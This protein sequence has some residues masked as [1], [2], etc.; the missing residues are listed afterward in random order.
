MR[1]ARK[2]TSWV[3]CGCILLAMLPVVLLL[4]ASVA[5]DLEES[6]LGELSA[7]YESC[8]DP[9]AIAQVAGDPGGK[10]YG[11]YMFSSRAGVPKAFFEWCQASSNAYYRGIGNTL[12]EIYYYGTPGYGPLFDR[13][14]KSLAADNPVGFGRAQRDFVRSMYYDVYV[15]RIAQNVE[16]FDISNYS[17]ALRNV[18]WSRAIQHGVSGATNVFTRAMDTLGG[19]TNQPERELIDA[20]YAESGRLTVGDYP[21]MSGPTAR[22][23]GV[24]GMSMY[25]YTGCS[26]EIQLGVY[27]RLRINEPANAQAMLAEYGYGDAPVGEGS[28]I[29]CPSG[30]DNLAIGIGSSGLT[31]NTR[32]DGDDQQF[33]L[34][35]Y[36]SGYYTVTNAS[37]D[38][39]LTASASGVSLS[40][41]TAS[42]S[43]FWS[44]VPFNSGFLLKNRATDKC[45]SASSFSAGGQI[46]TSGENAQWQL[47]PGDANWSLDGAS[48]PSYASGL[49]VG[50]STFPFRGT[51]RS[52]YNITF[53]RAEVLNAS[54]A[55]C[56]YAEAA[57]D[58]PYYDLSQMD[59]AMTFGQLGAG[60]YTMRIT[61]TDSSDSHFELNE[62]FIVSDGNYMVTFD[63]AGG[64]C[65]VSARTFEAG[66]ILGE[67]P[68]PVWEGHVFVGWYDENGTLYT[69]ASTTPAHNLLLIARYAD[70]YTYTFYDYDGTTVLTSGSLLEGEVIP[71][72]ADPIR[73]SDDTNYYVFSGWEG[74]ESGMTM[75]TEDVSFTAQ[76]EA[77]PRLDITE[78]VPTGAFSLT[79]GYLRTIPVGTTAQEILNALEPHE[80]ITIRQGGET[81]TGKVGTGMTVD[82]IVDGNVIQSAV[83]VVTGDVNGDGDITLTDMVQIRSHLLGRSSLKDA[84]AEA[85]DLN[86]DDE[87][88]LTDFVQT[89]SA[90]L[91]RTTI[92]PN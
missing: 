31:L 81:V 86:G 25:Y 76:Y 44:L 20:I 29:L 47:A 7:T 13:T 63:P 82:F 41:P 77:F 73:P 15:N 46:T 37:N 64:V 70:A 85:A 36:A 65:D 33:R 78:M 38:L 87:L 48:Y 14:W 35:Y 72:P 66:Q 17:I 5:D 26:G 83:I 34:V 60:L 18:L 4:S 89:L 62:P 30:N 55:T 80:Y 56:F 1:S 3:L 43:Q 21:K 88:T 40:A 75:G 61:A 79:D 23:L 59:A 28:Y 16:G 24:E 67:L 54:G 51:L 9:G 68:T 32:S 39:R 10:S 74:Y 71:A 2:I 12:S 49:R 84:F 27:I 90:V 58:A 52:T 91:G 92:K 19:F 6:M 57:P 22:R 11:L 8:G 50:N 69:A 42:D 45:L 53:V